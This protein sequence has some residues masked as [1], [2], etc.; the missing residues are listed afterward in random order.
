M[1]SNPATAASRTALPEALRASPTAR[2]VVTTPQP[3]WIM[4]S[5]SVSPSLRAC[6][7]EVDC[8]TAGLRRGSG[9]RHADRVEKYES[10]GRDHIFRNPVESDFGYESS[11]V[12]GSSRH[13]SQLISDST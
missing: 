5:S 7:C 10:G 8:R 13:A 3:A 11:K 4:P 6:A 2:A 9:E 12:F 1:T